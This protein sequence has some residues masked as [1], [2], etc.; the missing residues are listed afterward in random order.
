MA[1]DATGCRQSKRQDWIVLANAQ[2]KKLFGYPRDELLGQPVEMLIPHRFRNQHPGHCGGFFA[3]RRPRAMGAGA[4]SHEIRTPLNAIVGY[5][6]LMRDPQLSL[7]KIE[8]GRTEFSFNAVLSPENPARS[9]GYL[10]LRAEAKALHFEMLVG[11]EPLLYVAAD[12]GK[13]CQV[14]IN[15]VGN[16]SYGYNSLTELLTEVCQA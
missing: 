13:L 4:M 8:A 2:V 7:S 9:G 1:S 14:M 12:E 3:E 6:Q 16:D 10:R 11:G 15:L 5:A